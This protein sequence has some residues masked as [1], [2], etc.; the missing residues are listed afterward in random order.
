MAEAFTETPAA[1]TK[2][3]AEPKAK[4]NLTDRLLKSLKPEKKP[5]EVMDTDV[6]GLGIRMMP[7]RGEDLYSPPA[8][9]RLEKS[10]AA[11]AWRLR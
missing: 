11:R 4:V 8:L 5:Y 6:R 7:T 9:S 10:C 3:K 2:E 1:P